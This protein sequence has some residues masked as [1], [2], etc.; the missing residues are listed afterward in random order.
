MKYTLCFASRLRCYE[1][2]R[3][4]RP[5]LWPRAS[6]IVPNCV[7]SNC[8]AD[9][10]IDVINL[11]T[12]KTFL[13]TRGCYIKK[14]QGDKRYSTLLLWFCK[15]YLLNICGGKRKLVESH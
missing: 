2:K 1:S 8:I 5:A 12:K 15:K 10:Y 9:T 4:V 7:R 11:R 14:E 13:A 6:V 3:A